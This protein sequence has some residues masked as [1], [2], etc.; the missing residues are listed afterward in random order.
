MDEA[1]TIQEKLRKGDP[2]LGAVCERAA[3]TIDELLAACKELLHYARNCGAENQMIED[4]S[5][6]IALAE[7]EGTLA[8]AGAGAG[9]TGDVETNAERKDANA[10][11]GATDQEPSRI[12]RVGEPAAQQDDRLSVTE[13][14]GTVADALKE[15]SN[16]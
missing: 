13:I 6:A 11:P 4:A 9:K 5:L 15:R 8:A 2:H 7:N 14:V 1:M 10:A 12:V 3:D 16:G